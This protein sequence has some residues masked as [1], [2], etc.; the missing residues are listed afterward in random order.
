MHGTRP[1]STIRARS[2]RR[3]SHLRYICSTNVVGR[4]R[5]CWTSSTVHPQLRGHVYAFIGSGF[6]NVFELQRR[7]SSDQKVHRRCA[8]LTELSRTVYATR[9]FLILITP[10]ASSKVPFASSSLLS[11]AIA[12]T[13]SSPQ[14]LSS[15]LFASYLPL[16]AT[17][18]FAGPQINTPPIP[19]SSECDSRYDT[20]TKQAERA[21][22]QNHSNA[23][24]PSH[25]SGH[26]YGNFSHR[27]SHASVKFPN[28]PRLVGSHATSDSRRT[29]SKFPFD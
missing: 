21:Q 27:S 18:S 3:R 5:K 4:T 9:F 28:G 25:S 20:R 12:S 29:V 2:T 17:F 19:V 10:P 11:S 8:T 23:R 14:R 7:G 15:T 6:G 22:R 16:F 26:G 1:C 13:F 24:T